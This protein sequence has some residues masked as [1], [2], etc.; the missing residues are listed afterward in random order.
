MRGIRSVA[1][2]LLLAL[3]LR[4]KVLQNALGVLAAGDDSL[5][6]QNMQAAKGPETWGPLALKDVL[7]LVSV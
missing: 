7:I 5:Y 3:Q 2:V 6:T 4:R 1:A